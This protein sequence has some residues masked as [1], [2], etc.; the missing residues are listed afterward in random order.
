MHVEIVV[1]GAVHA[2]LECNWVGV[3]RESELWFCI[4]DGKIG[5]ETIRIWVGKR[6]F[7]SGNE[8]LRC[9]RSGIVAQMAFHMKNQ[10]QNSNRVTDI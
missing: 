9:V 7:V 4:F 10:Y 1:V 3:G 2:G 5:W 8:F 6:V